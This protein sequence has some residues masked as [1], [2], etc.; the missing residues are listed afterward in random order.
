MPLQSNTA[1]SH[2]TPMQYVAKVFSIKEH[3]ILPV[4][5]HKCQL[6]ASNDS[7]SVKLSNSGVMVRSGIMA[8]PTSVLPPAQNLGTC[9]C[10]HQ[11]DELVP[12]TLRMV[13]AMV[14]SH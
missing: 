10:R 8:I 14:L 13:D 5:R 7:E 6:G 4:V 9:T 1:I 11:Q 12:I 2:V 3:G